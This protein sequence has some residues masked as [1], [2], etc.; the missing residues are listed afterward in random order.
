MDRGS[1]INYRTRNSSNNTE[2]SKNVTE[3]AVTQSL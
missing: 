1:V 3:N 2:D